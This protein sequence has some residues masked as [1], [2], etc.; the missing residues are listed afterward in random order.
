MF[1][2]EGRA[3]RK[4]RSRAAQRT[5]AFIIGTNSTSQLP[6][7][8]KIAVFLD[9]CFWHGY[10]EHHRPAQKNSGFW[11]S[12]IEGNKT[13]DADTDSRLREAGWR[14]IRIWEHEDPIAAARMIQATLR[15][16]DR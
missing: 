5:L 3:P 11:V 12:K 14:A 8:A 7:M 9:G 16:D 1:R 15:K 13:R 2:G 6:Y 10:P 4:K